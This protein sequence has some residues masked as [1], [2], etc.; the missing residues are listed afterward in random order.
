GRQLLGQ[1][2]IR[3]PAGSLLGLAPPRPEVNLVDR[4]WSRSGVGSLGSSRGPWNR[5]EVDHDRGGLRPD[6]GGEGDRIRFQRHP[7]PVRPDD[8]VFV[9]IAGFGVGHEDFPKAVAAHPHGVAAAIPAVEVADHA[10]APRTGR[11]HRETDAWYALEHHR[12]G[13]ELPVE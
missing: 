2:T 3:K 1:F 8:L 11:E 10:D 12:V 5:V 13:A 7:L 4:D 9:A 6:L